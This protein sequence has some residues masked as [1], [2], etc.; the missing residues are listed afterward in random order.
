MLH[1]SHFTEREKVKLAVFEK[2]SIHGDQCSWSWP[3]GHGLGGTWETPVVCMKEFEM[4]EKDAQ[5]H[6]WAEG[7]Q[8]QSVFSSSGPGVRKAEEF[9]KFTS[10]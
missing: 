2:S 9:S 4:W 7:T 8:K 10:S 6:G 1:V 5:G 3:Q